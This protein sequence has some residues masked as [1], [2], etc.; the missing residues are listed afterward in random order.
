MGEDNSVEF[1][2]SVS[3]PLIG[4]RFDDQGANLPVGMRGF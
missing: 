4:Y 2:E 3:R 1:G